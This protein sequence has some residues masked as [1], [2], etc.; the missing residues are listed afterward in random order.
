M[1]DRKLYVI[2]RGLVFS[3][4]VDPPEDPGSDESVPDWSGLQVRGSARKMPSETRKLKTLAFQQNHLQTL[5]LRHPAWA[6][7]FHVVRKWLSAKMLLSSPGVHELSELILAS[8]F[9]RPLQGKNA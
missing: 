7:A 2:F 3:L 6:G 4:D 8:I 9:E 5:G 1:K